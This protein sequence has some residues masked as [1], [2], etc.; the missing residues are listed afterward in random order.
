MCSPAFLFLKQWV[1]VGDCGKQNAYTTPAWSM[2]HTQL[3]H[4]MSYHRVSCVC[5]L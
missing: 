5:R 3:V 4:R 1:I 2:R